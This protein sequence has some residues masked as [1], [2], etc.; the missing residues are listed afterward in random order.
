[1]KKVISTI[2]ILITASL[3]LWHC[4]PPEIAS[5]ATNPKND[6]MA[7]AKDSATLIIANHLTNDPGNLTFFLYDTIVK[8]YQN[9]GAGIRLNPNKGVVPDGGTVN[10]KVPVGFWR[11][12]CIDESRRIFPMDNS[13]GEWVK[14]KFV[15]GGA[16]YIEIKSNTNANGK[17]WIPSY[18]TDPAITP[19]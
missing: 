14:S 6:S 3:F 15:K 19:Q 16:Y 9:A 12:T 11:I 4:E 5:P 7:I 8:D 2:V 18:T 13:P 17:D 1:M 10:F